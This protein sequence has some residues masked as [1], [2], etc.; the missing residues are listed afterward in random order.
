MVELLP[1]QLQGGVLVPPEFLVQAGEVG[2]RPIWFFLGSGRKQRRLQLFLRHLRRQG[3]S[4]TG[5]RKTFQ[6]LV[7]RIIYSVSLVQPGMEASHR[8]GPSTSSFDVAGCVE[9]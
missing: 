8:P 2:L 5:R 4:Q 3:P 1:Q 9:S 6:I 7:D